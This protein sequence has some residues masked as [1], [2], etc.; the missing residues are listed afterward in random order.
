MTAPRS[1]HISAEEIQLAEANID[2]TVSILRALPAESLG[3]L[4]PI[5]FPMLQRRHLDPQEHVQIL[6]LT[7]GCLFIRLAEQGPQ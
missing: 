6:C 1:A 2:M 5:V 7:I 4:D 3:D